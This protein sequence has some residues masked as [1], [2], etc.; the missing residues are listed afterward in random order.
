MRMTDAPE[1][2]R[3]VRFYAVY[4]VALLAAMAFFNTVDMTVLPAVLS[5]IQAEFHLS[6][7]EL[8]LLN[9]AFTVAFAVSAIPIGYWADRGSR[10]M[11]IGLGVAVWSLFTLLTGLTQ[12]FAQMLAVRSVVGIGEASYQP[13]GGSLIGDYYD[14]RSRGRANA[15]VVTL[16]GLGI[17]GGFIIGGAVGLQF[18]WRAAFFLVAGPGLLLALLAFTVREPLRGAAESAG[19]R[20]AAARDTGFRAFGRLLRVRSFVAAVAASVLSLFGFSILGFLPLYVERRFGLDLA[21][22][23]GL[24][25]LPQ[26]AAT[27]LATPLVGALID[28]RA[29]RTPRAAVEIGFG[30]TLL[31][32]LGA[33]VMFT[34]G[35]LQ[36]FV[37]G[38][39]VFSV[40]ATAATLAPIVITQNV[41]VPSLRASAGSL[42]LTAS[43]LLG[44]ALSP[45]VVGAVSD[46]A[47]GNLGMSML[48]LGPSAFVLSAGSL[49]LALGSMKRDAAAMEASWA[50]SR[51]PEAPELPTLSPAEA[52]GRA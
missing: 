44:S 25:G 15:A 30:G 18:G 38:E 17:G 42:N 12:S 8:G 5:S 32:G 51:P 9:A 28:W 46:L 1:P 22:A 41:V 11:I 34:A 6:D 13:A 33:I 50:A 3:R 31:A 21:Q 14:K 7:T 10:R 27:I 23:G 36:V 37:A 48:V 2:R 4:A 26:L 49:A 39:I 24:V 52:A 45:I 19:P 43:R 16:G 40:M 47:H 35:A 29:R 20:L